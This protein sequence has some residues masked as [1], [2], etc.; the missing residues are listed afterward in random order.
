MTTGKQ[1]NSRFIDSA[2]VTSTDD[3]RTRSSLIWPGSGPALRNPSADLCD[4]QLPALAEFFSGSWYRAPAALSPIELSELG[5]VWV[6]LT[7]GP[8]RVRADWTMT[9]I[10]WRLVETTQQE[11]SLCADAISVLLPA[12]TATEP[13]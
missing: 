6:L 10:V 9:T 13:A 11:W 12:N 2:S 1:A 3:S 4:D 8:Q 7:P 5:T